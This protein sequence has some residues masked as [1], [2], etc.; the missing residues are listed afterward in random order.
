MLL[1]SNLLS[2]CILFFFTFVTQFN[3][4]NVEIINWDL[5]TYLVVADELGRGNLIYEHQAEPKAPLIFYILYFVSNLLNRN[6]FFI[7]MFFD[8][9]IF[10]IS[11][12][13]FLISLKS[14][15]SRINALISSLIFISLLSIYPYGHSES[16]EIF[17]ILFILCALYI[18][19][20]I[21]K[22]GNNKSTV[23]LTI[24]A[25][26]SFS[27][28]I[29]T[30]TVVFSIPFI[31]NI[32][33]KNLINLFKFSIGFVSPWIIYLILYIKND[34]LTEFIYFNFLYTITYPSGE[35]QIINK[36]IDNIKMLTFDQFLLNNSYTIFMNFFNLLFLITLFV[37]I[38]YSFRKNL[39]NIDYQLVIIS[40]LFYFLAGTGYFHFFF[41]FFSF[42]PLLLNSLKN[43]IS[44]I[45]IPLV[46]LNISIF[47]IKNFDTSL[48]ILQ[49]IMLFLRTTLCINFIHLTVN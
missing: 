30:S 22:S 31:V 26:L 21:E 16:W 8:L 40:I 41:F 38:A 10:L 14:T 36:T 32:F 18:F 39:N 2:I 46:L 19:K 33:R 12:F 17:S 20:N 3:S 13:I 37:I 4:L 44:Y 45:L 29:S 43:Q 7:K 35:N 11:I 48:K 34:L 47:T 6:F 28:L 9:L 24:G 27:T 15:K 5:G 1:N 49:I 25:L 42:A 23:Y